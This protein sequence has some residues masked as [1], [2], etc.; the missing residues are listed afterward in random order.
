MH[1]TEHLCHATQNEENG[2]SMDVLCRVETIGETRDKTRWKILSFPPGPCL[3]TLCKLL[4]IM[5]FDSQAE[6][7][8]T[9]GV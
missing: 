8:T 3:S 1:F 2:E 9:Q 7:V 4:Y 5:C 6:I